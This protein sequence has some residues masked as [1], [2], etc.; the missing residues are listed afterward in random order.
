LILD[1]GNQPL[2]NSLRETSDNFQEQRYPLRLV[3]CGKCGL[4]QIDVTVD[5]KLM[6]TD[7]NWVTSTSLSS[8][9]HCNN[10]VRESIQRGSHKPL[11][12]LEI[13]SNDGT[14]LKEYAKAGVKK[15]VGIEPA[16]NL[17]WGYGEEMDVENLFFNSI[18][19][20]KLLSRYGEFEFI[21]A[22][23]VFSHV[24]DFLDVARG[25]SALMNLKSIFFIEF[26]WAYEILQGLHYDSIYHEHT[27]YHSIS[28]ITDVLATVGLNVYDVFKSPISGG[29][30]VLLATKDHKEPSG[31]LTELR[32]LE[33]QVKIR[34]FSTWEQ[35][36]STA[37]K[38]IDE[39]RDFIVGSET[40]RICAFGAS[41]R[42]STILNSIGER[43]HHILSIGDNNP[44]KWGKYAPGLQI[45]IES[46]EKMI[47]RD[48]EVIVVFP[49]N[50]KT[51]ILDQLV[52]L[53]WSGM[54]FFPI[55]H[56]PK[57]FSI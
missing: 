23:N 54:V 35:F 15:L 56:P 4:L 31:E 48:P 13:G 41:A 34:D 17:T 20:Y 26:H 27:Y 18:N 50:F 29:S 24:P 36:G 5:P 11:S 45:P 49:F 21:V 22:R 46:V 33:E 44:R 30:V 6:F 25:I 38:N 14:L 39:L 43:A 42:S 40:R 9:Q 51:E 3:H 32:N 1:L 57:L 8:I 52:K 2:A 12:I 37:L 7:Y 53:N 47:S 16:S 10:F 28:G 19:A 55:P